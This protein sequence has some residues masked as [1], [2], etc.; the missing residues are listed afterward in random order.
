[1]KQ[2]QQYKYDGISIMTSCQWR[3][4]VESNAGVVVEPY[5]L[6]K[7][8]SSMVIYQARMYIPSCPVCPSKSSE[9]HIARLLLQT[10]PVIPGSD[11]LQTMWSA[12]SDIPDKE[13]FD[14]IPEAI[15]NTSLIQNNIPRRRPD[16]CMFVT[17]S[18][19]RC[20]RRPS[21]N[22]T[23]DLDLCWQHQGKPK[24]IDI[25]LQTKWV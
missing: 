25:G 19:K 3:T 15:C 7:R 10:G 2:L 6:A 9:K 11:Q 18:G 17:S 22:V 8:F 13:Q 16:Q 20:S 14:W 24:M 12:M 5:L 1:M 23:L 21:G 4:V